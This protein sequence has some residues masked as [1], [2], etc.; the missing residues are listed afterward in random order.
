VAGAALALADGG[1]RARD[2]RRRAG[3]DAAAGEAA[4]AVSAA[5]EAVFALLQVEPAGACGERDADDDAEEEANHGRSL[6]TFR[7]ARRFL[8]CGGRQEGARADRAPFD[9]GWGGRYGQV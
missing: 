8:G 1:W 4:R 7:R 5:A 2:R 3:G 6:A 9:R